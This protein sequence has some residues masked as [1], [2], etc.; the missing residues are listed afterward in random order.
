MYLRPYAHTR[1]CKHTHVSYVFQPGFRKTENENKETQRGFSLVLEKDV[2]YTNVPSCKYV[3][4]RRHTYTHMHEHGHA[5]V[6]PGRS[7]LFH[8]QC[9]ATTPYGHRPG[10]MI[11]EMSVSVPVL[12]RVCW[13]VSQLGRGLSVRVHHAEAT[14]DRRS[15]SRAGRTGHVAISWVPGFSRG[16]AVRPGGRAGRSRVGRQTEQLGL[17]VLQ[18]IQHQGGLGRQV[19][20]QVPIRNHD[21]LHA[22]CKGRV[23]AV[24]SVFK[25]EA[26]WGRKRDK[27]ETA[28]PGTRHLD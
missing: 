13:A 18:G 5:S 1:M 3:Y 10:C 11:M 15:S 22:S 12:G 9:E 24:G 8:D 14:G 16:G 2:F 6:C 4:I 21:H 28:F 26:L 7:G 23:H 20:L 27:V 17:E 19:S 25:H